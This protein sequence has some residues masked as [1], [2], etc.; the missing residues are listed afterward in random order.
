MITV[1]AATSLV[2]EIPTPM[3]R[4]RRDRISTDRLVKQMS[5]AVPEEHRPV[6]RPEG[7]DGRIRVMR[8]C[9]RLSMIR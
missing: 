1:R 6:G 2:R 8:S 5:E 4:S 3:A 9:E 7:R